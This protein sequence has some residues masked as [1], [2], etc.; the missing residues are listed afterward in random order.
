MF[1]K[2]VCRHWKKSDKVSLLLL[3]ILIFFWYHSYWLVCVCVRVWLIYSNEKNVNS[4]LF[5]NECLCVISAPSLGLIYQVLKHVTHYNC[6]LG[7]LGSTIRSACIIKWMHLTKAF[8]KNFNKLMF[9]FIYSIIKNWWMRSVVHKHI[10]S[11]SKP[12]LTPPPKAQAV[13]AG[14][15]FCFMC[16]CVSMS[17]LSIYAYLRC[18]SVHRC[19]SVCMG[20]FCMCFLGGVTSFPSVPYP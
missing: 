13:P 10:L 4:V 6:K 15:A 5:Y 16:P 1:A 3:W 18:V 12:F 2:H 9:L 14:S 8:K 11:E 17:N 7:C 20:F 19:L